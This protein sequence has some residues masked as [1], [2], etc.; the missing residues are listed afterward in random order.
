MYNIHYIR[1]KL[2]KKIIQIHQVLVSV[3]YIFFI[4]QLKNI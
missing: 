3:D 4:G 1:I 2:Y